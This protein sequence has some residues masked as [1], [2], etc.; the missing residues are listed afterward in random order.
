MG[1]P[2]V[3]TKL[4]AMGRAAREAARELRLA[5]AQT[6]TRAI[7]AMARRLGA[8]REAEIDEAIAQIGDISRLRLFD[9]VTP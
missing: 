5:S 4:D 8:D 3:K 2:A 1:D 7:A 9:A 6:R